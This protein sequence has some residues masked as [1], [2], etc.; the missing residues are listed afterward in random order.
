MCL[1]LLPQEITL[2]E[3]SWH[4]VPQRDPFPGASAHSGSP[5]CVFIGIHTSPPADFLLLWIER[6]VLAP[7]GEGVQGQGRREHTPAQPRAPLNPSRETKGRRR[8]L[9]FRRPPLFG[10]QRRECAHDGPHGSEDLCATWD[11]APCPSPP[12]ERNQRG[13]STPNWWR[14]KS[15][16]QLACSL[17]FGR[18]G[19]GAPGACSSLLQPLTRT[20]SRGQPLPP[21]L[22]S[23]GPRTMPRSLP[24]AGHGP[25]LARQLRVR[26]GSRAP[27]APPAALPTL[28]P[29]LGLGLGGPST[30]HE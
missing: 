13:S 17:V 28:L 4:L 23:Q 19:A 21:C 9:T 15:T 30:N 10:L 18:R 14:K 6:P 27:P 2:R 24:G 16:R 26:C 5:F 11:P 22:R 8:W 1:F 25:R 20:A 29:A 12:L 7:H 3:G